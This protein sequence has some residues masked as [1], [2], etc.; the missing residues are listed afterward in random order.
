MKTRC[1]V[2]G[3]EQEFISAQDRGLQYGDGVFETMA[4]IDGEVRRLAQHL[5]RLERGCAGLGIHCPPRDTLFN[6]CAWSAARANASVLNRAVLKLIVTRGVGERGYRVRE[7]ALPRRVVSLHPWP[8]HPPSWSEEGV[9]VRWCSL[10]LSAQPLL[11]GIKHLNRLE[12]VLA[13]REWSDADIAEGLL[14]DTHGQVIG[15]T[16]SNLFLIV[17]DE[18]V[19]P[20]LVRCGVAGTM[21]SA[22]LDLA[23][24]RRL[25]ADLGLHVSERDVLRAELETA[26]EVFLTN[27][28]IGIWPVR[29]VGERTLTVG[30]VT[31]RLQGLLFAT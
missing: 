5:D 19:T 15:G 21:R 14:C 18:L 2:N 27:A 20:R 28:L 4:V 7:G 6:E 3:N 30:S 26:R 22:V 1:W 10:N 23:H 25:T 16:A 12:N 9:V 29:Q 13:R 8:H 11:A 24:E 17:G 31:R